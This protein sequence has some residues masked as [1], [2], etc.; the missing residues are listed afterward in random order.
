M[1]Y[2]ISHGLRPHFIFTDVTTQ[3]LAEPVR[4]ITDADEVI[5]L[6]R[7]DQ[8]DRGVEYTIPINVRDA[9]CTFISGI[10]PIRGFYDTIGFL[11]SLNDAGANSITNVQPEP[12][13]ER[14]DKPKGRGAA[15]FKWQARIIREL[16]DEVIL[17][18]P[19]NRELAS[20]IYSDG[21]PNR[22]LKGA[23]MLNMTPGFAISL[24]SLQE[25]G[26]IEKGNVLPLYADV[27]GSK[28]IQPHDRECLKRELGWVYS[29]HADDWA[30]AITKRNPRTNVKEFRGFD[31]S[32]EEIQGTTAIVFEDIGDS[33]NTL[34]TVAE[35]FKERDGGH[36]I[37]CVTKTIASPHGPEITD[38]DFC[39]AI[40]R[41]DESGLIDLVITTDFVDF[42]N[43]P[44]EFY[45]DRYEAIQKSPIFHVMSGGQ[46][47]GAYIKALRTTRNRQND[48]NENS[49]QALE[50]GVHPDYAGNG[51]SLVDPIKLKPDNPLRLAK[52][53]KDATDGKLG[54]AGNG[55]GASTDNTGA[56][57]GRDDPPP[58]YVSAPGE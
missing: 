39:A 18:D 6:E 37:A 33:F 13:N 29:D 15:T 45:P 32:E 28:R 3:H 58:P 1:G 9:D 2:K 16:C 38:G 49:I 19:H 36:F 44:P 20:A 23:T 21:G 26:F 53:E 50:R 46:V 52:E 24:R 57:D 14:A 10:D 5:V 31:I 25:Q 54:A 48:P 35:N 8:P 27:G 43:V 41:V 11:N 17:V 22:R 40:K 51:H 42:R 55:L 56:S 7:L 47:T 4:K 12:F 30:Q 34:L